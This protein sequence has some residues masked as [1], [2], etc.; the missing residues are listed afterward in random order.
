[1]HEALETTPRSPAEFLVEEVQ[2]EGPGRFHL[3]AELSEDGALLVS[4]E[5]LAGR[6]YL[7]LRLELPGHDGA[8]PVF[9]EILSERLSGQLFRREVRFR[10][11]FGPHRAALRS[12]VDSLRGPAALRQE[13]RCRN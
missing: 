13:L 10:H 11:V 9:A 2:S 4:G 1:M 8:L 3:V 12:F 7:W 6:R 5:A